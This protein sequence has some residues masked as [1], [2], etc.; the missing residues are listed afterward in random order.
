MTN[1]SGFDFDED[2][3]V[4]AISAAGPDAQVVGQ[5]AAE[6]PVDH[7]KNDAQ[8]AQEVSSPAQSAALVGEEASSTDVHETEKLP[9]KI[10]TQAELDA[11]LKA[12]EAKSTGTIDFYKDQSEK[13][14]DSAD[15]YKERLA[16][17][18]DHYRQKDSLLLRAY[19]ELGDGSPSKLH[20]L[21]VRYVQVQLDCGRISEYCKKQ[22]KEVKDAKQI[23]QALAD[24]TQ[25]LDDKTREVVRLRDQ[26][27]D[28][29]GELS[30]FRGEL[31]RK[32]ADLC[33]ARKNL[34]GWQEMGNRMLGA[35][36]PQCLR[37]KDWFEDDFLNK[38]Q[39]QVFAELPSDAAILVL[40]SLS[41]FAVMERS[42]AT[43]CFDW[44][45]QLS[46][47]G[48]VVAN[49]MHQMNVPEPDVIRKLQDFSAA[50]RESPTIQD[51]RIELFIPSLGPGFN[52]DRVKHLK[53]GTSVGK[54]INWGILDPNGTYAKAIVE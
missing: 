35:I 28:I 50:L 11:Q 14:K 10:Y 47:I 13:Y 8:N 45:K 41:E 9:E 37:N 18:H 49:Y 27:R 38:L 36:V 1:D 43:A 22:E 31:S 5:A 12:C 46:D 48:L 52:S 51:L 30:T 16:Q 3:K 25:E 17:A 24:K 7:P 44:R 42:P 34:E 2:S 20:E 39:Q 19:T 32:E 33:A 4:A 23:A 53:K 29:E 6:A 21:I 54:I 26:M 15:D 40:A